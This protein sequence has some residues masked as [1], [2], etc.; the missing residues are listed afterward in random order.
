MGKCFGGVLGSVGK[1]PVRRIDRRLPDGVVPYA[2][3]EFL[4]TGLE[5]PSPCVSAGALVSAV[6]TPWRPR[7]GREFA[8]EAVMPG[9]ALRARA[10]CGSLEGPLTHCKPIRSAA[11]AKWARTIRSPPPVGDHRPTA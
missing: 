9:M 2:R 6:L 3:P 4:P 10:V 11:R 5:S 7:A 8:G 1:M